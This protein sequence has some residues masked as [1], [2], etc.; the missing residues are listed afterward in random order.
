MKRPRASARAIRMPAGKLTAVA[1]TATRKDSLIAVSSSRVR[2]STI[3]PIVPR[4][5][6]GSLE[7]RL[8]GKDAKRLVMLGPYRLNDVSD[9]KLPEP[10]Y[11]R[12]FC[13][14]LIISDI[15]VVSTPG[16]T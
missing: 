2:F 5:S 13:R 16:I 1:T 6:V 12:N 11:F 15:D 3:A 9:E 10:S 7:R 4:T 8:N 14:Y